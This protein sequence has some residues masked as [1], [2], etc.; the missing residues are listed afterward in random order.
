MIYDVAQDVARCFGLKE[1]FN[2]TLMETFT[3]I[4]MG[5]FLSIRILLPEFF[6]CI[7]HAAC[8][9]CC[10]GIFIDFQPSHAS[11]QDP[12]VRALAVAS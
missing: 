6:L 8:Y 10:S 7:L 9:A 4:M 5:L 12:D 3:N 1:F 2:K 11:A